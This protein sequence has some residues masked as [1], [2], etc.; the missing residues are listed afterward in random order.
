MKTRLFIADKNGYIYENGKVCSYEFISALINFESETIDYTC[1]IGGKDTIF[2][3]YGCPTI[4][5]S[6]EKFHMDEP[7][8]PREITWAECIREALFWVSNSVN[9][10]GECD[11]YCVRNNEVVCCDAPKNGFLYLS[12]W[13]ITYS[14]EEKYFNTRAEALL[15]CD[16]IYVNEKGEEVVIPSITKRVELNEEQALAVENVR[17]ALARARDLNVGF[18]VDNDRED[19]YAYSREVITKEEYDCSSEPISS[20]GVRIN[21]F[22]SK[23]GTRLS[24]IMLCDT[25]IYAKF[26]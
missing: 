15:M 21:S 16:T 23:V 18:Y 24:T 8:D 20:Y 22:L 13:D 11:I 4:Y 2:S 19:L 12:R 9:D 26:K 3:T 7:N 1:K 10:S 17:L 5:A 6:V 25:S 14:S